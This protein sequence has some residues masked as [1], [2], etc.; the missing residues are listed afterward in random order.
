MR[1]WIWD[2]HLPSEH[3]YGSNGI[4][5]YKAMYMLFHFAKAANN[6]C[7]SV[8]VL[9]LES[10]GKA[11]DSAACCWKMCM[12]PFLPI[13]MIMLCISWMCNWK[14]KHLL[15]SIPFY[16]KT[17]IRICRAVSCH[18]Q[19]MWLHRASAPLGAPSSCKSGLNIWGVTWRKRCE[20]NPAHRTLIGQVCCLL[21]PVAMTTSTTKQGEVRR[22]ALSR[23]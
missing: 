1:K 7:S 9:L 14:K 22:G 8:P 6:Q 17:C 10:D 12:E 13:M 4:I 16:L 19:T 3:K 2:L 20:N 23:R 15:T 21:R 5:M 18:F 11:P